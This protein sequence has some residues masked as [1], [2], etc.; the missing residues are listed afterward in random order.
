LTWYN[1]IHAKLQIK[2]KE[3]IFQRLF[4]N[5]TAE[6][7][8]GAEKRATEGTKKTAKKVRDTFNCPIPQGCHGTGKKCTGHL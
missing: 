1:C 3:T 7:A 6:K 8:E 4:L 2:E 5:I